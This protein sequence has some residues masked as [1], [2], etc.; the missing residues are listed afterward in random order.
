MCPY[1]LRKFDF[2]SKKKQT[3][4]EYLIPPLYAEWNSLEGK[5]FL[6]VQRVKEILSILVYHSC[7]ERSMLKNAQ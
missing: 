2:Q 7:V 3:T 6:P 5:R 1:I 4:V